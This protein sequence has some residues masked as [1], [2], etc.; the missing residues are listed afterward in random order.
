M[1]EDKRQTEKLPAQRRVSTL[2]N[3][4]SQ[5]DSLLPHPD[6]KAADQVPLE[7]LPEE[8]LPNVQPQESFVQGILLGNRVISEMSY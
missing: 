7:P 1:A 3:K 4:K 5:R 6:S 2:T 8:L